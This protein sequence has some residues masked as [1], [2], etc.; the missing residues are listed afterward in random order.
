MIRVLEY[1]FEV[2]LTLPGKEEK[3][4]ELSLEETNTR[5]AFEAAREMV[6][7]EENLTKLQEQY[8]DLTML[9]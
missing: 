1:R 8:I 2:V 7:K 4:Y 9:T 5:K 3:T 6:R